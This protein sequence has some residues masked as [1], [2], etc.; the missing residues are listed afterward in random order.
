MNIACTACS[1]RYGVADE[2]LI[3]KRVRITCKRCGTVLIVDGHHS[4]PRV[5]ASTSIPPSPPASNRPAPDVKPPAPLPEPPFV[6][7]FADGQQEPADVAQI[8][9]LH[10]SGRLGTSSLVWRDGMADWANPWDVEEIA[11][12]FRRMGYSRPTPAP[13]RLPL[14][15]LTE[16]ADDEATQIHRS[17][18]QH[19]APSAGD[20]DDTQVVRASELGAPPAYRSNRAGAP[21]ED[22][23][24]PTR[25]T[26]PSRRVATEPSGRR[27]SERPRRPSSL[28]PAPLETA[29]DEYRRARREAKARSARAVSS[30]PPAQQ[31][32]ADLFARQSQAGS[33]E[34][35]ARQEQVRHANQT[36][37]RVSESDAP[38]LTGARNE[39]SVLFSLDSLL[40]EK[41]ESVRPARPAR[42]ED[43]L[44]LDVGAPLPMAGSIAP[45][46]SAPDF[47]APVSA[48]PPTSLTSAP[49]EYPENRSRSRAWLYALAV[50]VL[51]GGGFAAWSTGALQPLLTK[52]GV[53][54]GPHSAASP[55]TTETAP[56][57]T[58][59]Q[60]APAASSE[61][62]ATASAS[63][64]GA[65]S[66]APAASATTTAVPPATSPPARPTNTAAAAATPRAPSTGTSTRASSMQEPASPKEP[67]A[68]KEAEPKESTP[69]AAEV[70]PFD[71]SAAKE[72]LSA[73]TANVGSCKEMGGPTGTGRVSITF[74]P[75]GRPTSVAV[76]GDLAGTTVGSCVARLYR[77]VRVPA[78]SGDAVTVA[79]SFSVD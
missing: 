30:R 52:V 5:T 8:V 15:K 72:A 59:V 19:E 3:G 4:P 21:G 7:A 70:G 37:A 25:V 26:D 12:A 76:S 54:A 74:A 67:V 14:Q 24:V 9:R 77:A 51:G 78:F 41:K 33:E 62:A 47:T 46:L 20:N 56:A 27:P 16:P 29:E 18:P 35:L 40:T 34:E 66:A 28:P 23:D 1:A 45:A 6:V 53:A 49:I 57:A 11:A 22:D 43:A 55:A 65:A 71:P 13:S 42:R 58:T 17:S 31:S 10:R 50:V 39:S 68:A 79:K 36:R 75:S 44:L 73:A 48:P 61:P 32:R 38:R 60:T 69:P 2:K 63:A 64:S